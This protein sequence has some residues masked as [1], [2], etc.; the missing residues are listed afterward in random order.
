[1]A[2]QKQAHVLVQTATGTLCEEITPDVASCQASWTGEGT[3]GSGSAFGSARYGLLQAVLDAS[4]TGAVGGGTAVTNTQADLRFHDD[5]I[6]TGLTEDAYLEG[7]I[8]L[9]GTAFGND[10][11][12]LVA[13]LN[14]FAGS[15]VAECFIDA[16]SGR[17]TAKVAVPPGG[18]IS[19]S[20]IFRLGASAHVPANTNGAD[21]ATMDYQSGKG[22]R[23]GGA[24]FTFNVVDSRGR[25]VRDASVT[26][27]SG[28]EYPTK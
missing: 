12:G 21:S 25:T 8:F 5:F 19:A 17:C 11:V 9:S 26:T 10:G 24:R 2:Q 22:K 23:L 15:A 28:T 7:A 13:Q 1:M 3:A 16:L 6:V 14:L 18:F 4:A 20:G 27:T